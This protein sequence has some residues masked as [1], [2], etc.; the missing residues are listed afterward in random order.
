[1]P[2]KQLPNLQEAHQYFA[3][4]ANNEAW[5]LIEQSDRDSH[6]NDQLIRAAH[7]S[8]YHWLQVGKG[9]HFQR[10]YWLLSHCYA[11]I[12]QPD[13]AAFYAEK[14]LALTKS[15]TV[16][17]FDRAYCYEA[18]SRVAHLQGNADDAHGYRQLAL[19]IADEIKDEQDKQIFMSDI[20][21]AINL[22]TE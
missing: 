6:A 13:Q 21:R 5:Q 9:F 18:L 14:C 1:M 20:N 12:E 3:V 2:N 16:E 10:G 17:T 4:T 15:E 7:T 11:L 8:L 19:D 22:E